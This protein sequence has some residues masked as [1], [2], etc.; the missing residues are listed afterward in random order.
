MCAAQVPR[1]EAVMNIQVYKQ[2][3]LDL[4]KSLSAR[5]E[6][7][8]AAGRDE[9]IDSTHDAGEASVADEVA[10]EQFAEAGLDS[11]VLKQVRDALARVDE[12]TFGKCIVDGAPIEEKRLAAVPWTPHCLTHEERLEAATQQK[13]PTL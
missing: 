12:G 7:A 2:R 13:R 11:A 6:R 8:V 5:T 1:C 9:F 4:E 10:S 3:L